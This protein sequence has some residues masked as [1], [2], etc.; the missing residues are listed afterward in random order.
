MKLNSNSEP[1]F[2]TKTDQ[3]NNKINRLQK[4]KENWIKQKLFC[5]SK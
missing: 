4:F 3:K 1:Y 2:N 5:E